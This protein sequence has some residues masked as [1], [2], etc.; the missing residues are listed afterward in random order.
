MKTSTVAAFILA[1]A[2]IIAGGT[3]MAGEEKAPVPGTWEYRAALETGSLPTSTPDKAAQASARVNSPAPTVE[4]GG[5]VYRVGID[6][7]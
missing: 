7:N 1:A 6:T 5:V 4:A 3:A 2:T